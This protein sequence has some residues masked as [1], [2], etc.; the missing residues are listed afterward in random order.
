LIDSMWPP[1]LAT[2][3]FTWNLLIFIQKKK[4]PVNIV[5]RF[6][7]VVY[8]PTDLKFAFMLQN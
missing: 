2:V 4:E 6:F 8:Q 7:T 3:S 5:C 1:E